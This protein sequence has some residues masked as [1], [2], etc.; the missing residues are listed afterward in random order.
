MTGTATLRP[1]PNR[2]RRKRRRP[3]RRRITEATEK[4]AMTHQEHPNVTLV[5]EGFEQGLE[6]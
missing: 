5:R 1:Y 3:P 4:A 6:R 2:R